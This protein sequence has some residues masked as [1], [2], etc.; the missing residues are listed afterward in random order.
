MRRIVSVFFSTAAALIFAVSGSAFGNTYY[1]PDDFPS[2][3]A[4]LTGVVNGDTIIVRDGIYSG[5]DNKNLDFGGRAI[6]LRSE[7]GPATCVIDCEGAGRGFYFHTGETSASVVDGFTITNAVTTYT[8]PGGFPDGYG[9]GM[10]FVGSCLPI[11]TNC[12]ITG[13]RCIGTEDGA[14]AGIHCYSY[15]SPTVTNCAITNNSAVW[16]GGI[17][18]NF[19]SS[20]TITNCTFSGNSARGGGGI[21]T[22]NDSWPIITNSIM[23]NDSA[24]YGPEMEVVQGSSLSVSYSD[25]EGGQAGAFVHADSVLYWGAGNIDA[26]PLFVA[27]PVGDH[28]LS[29]TAAG[30]GANSPC[31]D[32]GGGPA[33]TLGLNLYTTRTDHAGDTGPVDMGYHFSTGALTR[34]N[35]LS[36]A[37][38]SSISTSPSFNWVPAGGVNNVYAIDFAIPPVVPFWS[39]YENMHILIDAASWTM[40]A[41][42]WNLIPSGW[43]IYWR[44][45]GVDLNGSPPTLVTSDHVWAFYKE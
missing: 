27:G 45:R 43:R 3:Q 24:L 32:A 41:Q 38:L 5:A 35:L 25:V 34:I 23:W 33:A 31:A 18:C 10:L 20:P 7:N 42:M 30:Q 9:A 13:N 37:N 44:V 6:T 8:G 15:A 29:Q 1:V 4:A 14:G 36:P 28:Y 16:G 21:Y 17:E 2:V 40:P 11:I 12:V 26:N 22:A 19:S 39:T